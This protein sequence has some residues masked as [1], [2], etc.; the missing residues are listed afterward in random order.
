MARSTKKNRAQQLFKEACRGP[1]F[2]EDN[3]EAFRTYRCWS[4]TWL[5]PRLKQLIPELKDTELPP[6]GSQEPDP[7]W[8]DRTFA[9]IGS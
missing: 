8:K 1:A 3:V 6:L 9:G 2:D 7:F 5:L 4:T